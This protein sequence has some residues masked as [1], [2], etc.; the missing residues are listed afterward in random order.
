MEPKQKG[1]PPLYGQRMRRVCVSLDDYTIAEAK[2][3]GDGNIAKGIRKAFSPPQ[4]VA[5][6]AP[7]NQDAAPLDTFPPQSAPI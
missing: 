1:K 6:D 4:V 5:L 3:R 2:R 7:E